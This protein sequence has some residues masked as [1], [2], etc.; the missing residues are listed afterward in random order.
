MNDRMDIPEEKVPAPKKPKK[1]VLSAKG[2]ALFWEIY[3]LLEV[4]A[5]VTIVVMLGFAFLGRLN[6]VEGESMDK[7]LA[8]G[9]YLLISDLFYEPTPGDIV[10][11]HDIT[12]APYNDP[13]VKRVIAV[14]GQTVEI[15][16]STWTLKVDGEVVEEP[17]RYLDVGYCTLRAEYG[18]DRD[19]IFR[20]TVPENEVFV[21]GDNRNNSGDSRQKEIGT[22]DK[23]CVVGK[24]CL[25]L[26]P[27]SE[28]GIPD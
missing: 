28:F 1:P 26:F 15:D 25:R 24:A 20:L 19:G 22:V 11:V 4:V 16:F 13:I 21:L 10:V 12:A 14:G 17:Y 9:Q 7:T 27:L 8:E 23:R 3:D 2:K 5:S 18:I 6:I